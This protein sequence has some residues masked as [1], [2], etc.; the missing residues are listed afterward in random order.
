MVG[1][2]YKILDKC[3]SAERDLLSIADRKKMAKSRDLYKF[4]EALY[5]LMLNKSNAQEKIKQKVIIESSHDG[6]ISAAR[7]MNNSSQAR[8]SSKLKSK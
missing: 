1:K 6:S 2:K 5:D 8:R 4:G 7:T 3:E